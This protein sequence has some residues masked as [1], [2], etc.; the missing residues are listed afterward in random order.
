LYI[1]SLCDIAT[2]NA[3]GKMTKQLLRNT[4]GFPPYRPNTGGDVE[5][6]SSDVLSELKEVVSALAHASRDE[7]RAAIAEIDRA[8]PARSPD[9]LIK[10]LARVAWDNPNAP[11]PT[12]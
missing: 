6:W 5:G 9:D 4:Q 2:M 7:I 3:L 1:G 11:D 10:L 12:D 8:D